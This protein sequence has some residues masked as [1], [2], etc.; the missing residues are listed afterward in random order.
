[1]TS[2]T[3]YDDD[4]RAIAHAYI[5]RREDGALVYPAFLAAVDAYRK[6][7]PET[8]NGEA[9]LTVSNLL[10]EIPRAGYR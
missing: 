8:D 2:M 5:E 4:L 10:Q 3:T 1:M 7:H 9:A 6:R